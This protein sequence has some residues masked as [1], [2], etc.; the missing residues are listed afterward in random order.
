M[1]LTEEVK[2]EIREAIEAVETWDAVTE[3]YTNIYAYD[4]LTEEPIELIAE[5]TNEMYAKLIINALAWSQ[6][7]LEQI[8]ELEEKLTDRETRLRAGEQ[9]YIGLQAK[10]EILKRGLVEANINLA[11]LEEPHEN[12]PL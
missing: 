4:R 7:L 5:C 6:D 3:P 11:R 9:S 2:K 10:C 8:N 12:S 1:K